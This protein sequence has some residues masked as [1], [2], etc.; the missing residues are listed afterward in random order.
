MLN[1]CNHAL[2]VLHYLFLKL[3]TCKTLA[4]NLASRQG[5]WGRVIAFGTKGQ[6]MYSDPIYRMVQ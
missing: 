6:E 1:V 5:I 4:K 2:S 3:S